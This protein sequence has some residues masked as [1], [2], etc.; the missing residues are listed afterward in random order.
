MVW[1][2]GLDLRKPG[3]DRRLEEALR[4]PGGGTGLPK[5]EKLP[6]ELI[7]A[8]RRL[9]SKMAL[10]PWRR[11]PGWCVSSPL[12]SLHFLTWMLHS[13]S[14]SD[15]VTGSV[16]IWMTKH[17]THEINR[18]SEETTLGTTGQSDSKLASLNKSRSEINLKERKTYLL[19]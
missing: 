1:N 8:A 2:G 7:E 19:Y 13:L 6:P 9:Y 10:V 5:K 16:M 18:G 14:M 11:R 4:G 17:H 15:S 3:S 12:D